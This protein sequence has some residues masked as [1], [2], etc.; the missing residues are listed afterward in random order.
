MDG[1]F[2]IVNHVKRLGA[3]FDKRITRRLHIK[4][5]NAKALKIYYNL[6]STQSELVR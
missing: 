1:T 5:T 4:K 3:T 6:L 2:P